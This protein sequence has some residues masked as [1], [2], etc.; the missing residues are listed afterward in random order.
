MKDIYEKKCVTELSHILGDFALAIA[1]P[2][3]PFP[4]A[5]QGHRR[6]SVQDN[7]SNARRPADSYVNQ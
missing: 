4:A 3:I 1:R 5:P 2:P 7:A 6:A